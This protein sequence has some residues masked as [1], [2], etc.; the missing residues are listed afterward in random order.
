MQYKL[1]TRIDHLLVDEFQDTSHS[2]ITLLQ[3]LTAGWAEGD[4]RTL[5]LVGDPMQSIYRFRKAEVSLFIRAFD[6]R[7]FDQLRLTRLTLEVNFR[8]ARPV[9]DWV[10]RVFPTVM[11][12]DNDPVRGAVC[13]SPASVRPGADDGGAVGISLEALRD[14]DAEAERV[15]PGAVREVQ[16]EMLS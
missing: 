9:V 8:S 12:A 14:D 3:R 16:R 10:N 4:G 1:D 13:Y 5:F 2:Q 15:V 7:L 11:P 6:G